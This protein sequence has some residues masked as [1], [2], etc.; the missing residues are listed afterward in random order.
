MSNVELDRSALREGET[1]KYTSGKNGQL[2]DG[3]L[4]MEVFKGF[5]QIF[6]PKDPDNL[7]DLR[8][9]SNCCN[10]LLLPES[11]ICSQCGERAEI[12]KE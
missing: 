7:P 6:S 11:D 8:L 1:I 5:S 12:I 3:E 4:L 9:R 2:S 10:A